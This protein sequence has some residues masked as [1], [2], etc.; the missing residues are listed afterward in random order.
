MYYEMNFNEN[1]IS[2][3]NLISFI[4]MFWKL[5]V[6][7]T[8][9][10]KLKYAVHYTVPKCSIFLGKGFSQQYLTYISQTSSLFSMSLNI[11]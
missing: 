6:K 1:F 11:L 9:V 8:R 4:G 2:I 10:T 5:N 3:N 7:N